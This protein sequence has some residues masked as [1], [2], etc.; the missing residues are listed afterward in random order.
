MDDP[1]PNTT[2]FNG[3]ID[4]NPRKKTFAKVDY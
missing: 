4:K 3:F 1:K 2:N